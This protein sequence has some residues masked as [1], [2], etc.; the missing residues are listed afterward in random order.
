MTQR[1]DRLDTAAAFQGSLP[2]P[3][4]RRRLREAASLTHE[5]IAT[6]VGVTPS[7][8]RSWETGRS[9]PKGRRREAYTK[10]L[11]ESRSEQPSAPQPTDPAP[12]DHTPAE[13]P[14]RVAAA[15]GPRRPKAT[16]HVTAAKTT[17]PVGKSGPDRTVQPPGDTPAPHATGTRP[18]VTAQS[19]S[20]PDSRP[21][22]M[23]GVRGAGASAI[24]ASSAR[25]PAHD[26]AGAPTATGATPGPRAGRSPE[27][28][29]AEARP[30]NAP[31]AAGDEALRPAEVFDSLH[32]HISGPLVRQAYL[33]TG[34]G[35][36]AEEAVERAFTQA[37]QRWPEV[38]TDRDPI[39]W[40]RAAVH[41]YALSPWHRLR[42][43]QRHPDSPP[44]AAED[45][46]LLDA[47]LELP[48][49]HRRSLL[50]YDGVG[51]DLPET[52]AETEATTAATAQRLLHAHAAL[53]ERLPE[54]ADLTS[55]Q[56]RSAHLRTRLGALQPPEPLEPVAPCE[57]RKASESHARLWTR[58]AVGLT[59]LIAAATA[60]TLTTAPTEY[61]PEPAPGAAVSGVPPHSGPQKLTSK[62]L[63]L[64]KKLAEQPVPG[65]ERLVPRAE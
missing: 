60:Y 52:A 21:L 13:H 30:R 26:A 39:G 4:E 53:A 19:T 33:L 2:S 12:Q 7:T 64:R 25:P 36:L 45:R 23:A 24:G 15:D 27:A 10:L 14:R 61:R 5:D 49:T 9:S 11:T 38:A 63:Q 31:D 20:G 18:L 6:A 28:P 58:A 47:L 54:L 48:P 42:R 41:E 1:L 16:A 44:A 29:P 65:P 57:V 51:L 3:K 32:T 8:V 50:L 46:E 35:S 22:A 55:E 40:I 37:W 56:E 17:A 34:R 62:D 43:S 59:A